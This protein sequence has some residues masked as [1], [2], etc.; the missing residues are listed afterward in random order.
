MIKNFFFGDGVHENAQAFTFAFEKRR[1]FFQKIGPKIHFEH[2]N[3]M[4]SDRAIDEAAHA[5]AISEFGNDFIAK[6]SGPIP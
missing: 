6:P 1:D 4:R 2:R 5:N 3:R